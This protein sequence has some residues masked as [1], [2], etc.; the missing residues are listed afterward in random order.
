MS[1]GAAVVAI[2][3]LQI[4]ANLPYTAWWL[5]SGDG[6]LAT[7]LLSS[8]LASMIT[9]TT[10]VISITMVVLTLAASA[11]GPRLIRSFM[12]DRQTQFI[13][14]TYVATILYVFILLRNIDS[15]AGKDAV[16]RIAI[17]LGSALVL[18]CVCLLLF[19]VHHLGRSIIADVV[20]QRVG[21]DFDRAIR[22]LTRA[23]QDDDGSGKDE[24]SGETADAT[25]EC[26]AARFC[27]GKGGYFEAVDV[28]T[29]VDVARAAGARLRLTFRV[30]HH[31]V[32]GTGEVIVAPASALD[33]ALEESVNSAILTGPEPSAS[34][35]I[36]FSVR[37][38]AEI[39][40][41][42]LSAGTND[43]FTAIA[44]IDRLA[45]SLVLLLERG[46]IPTRYRDESGTV[47]LIVPAH[48]FADILDTAF[49]QIR[50]SATKRPD[51]L[52][53]MLQA[54]SSLLARARRDSD[55]DALNTHARMLVDAARREII[56]P[57]DLAAV[58]A[59]YAECVRIAATM[60]PPRR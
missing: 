42:A 4:D 2:G 57:Y 33:A 46:S 22:R 12:G 58:E 23:S 3:T 17:S 13:L 21:G 10:L 27:I 32:P 25:A 7:N 19:F 5:S 53:R 15:A 45:S 38:L 49:S 43:P 36:E 18:A 26:N 34:R 20:V 40:L 11:L 47:R 14:G 9:M 30:G 24:R 35:D 39:A 60:Q 28:G 51:I 54:I 44:V 55:R 31:L 52:I 29:L 6:A 37:Q 59:K 50:Q 48:S 16:P 56:E 8:L 1:A 41:R